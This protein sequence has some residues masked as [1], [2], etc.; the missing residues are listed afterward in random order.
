LYSPK[1]KGPK[2]GVPAPNVAPPIKRVS[3]AREAAFRVLDQIDN[4]PDAHSDDL[5]H[6]PMLSKLSQADKNL[7]TALVMGVLRWKIALEA[8]LIPLLARPDSRLPSQVATV[9]RLGAFQLLHMDRIPAHAAISESVDLVRWAGEPHS[10]GMVNAVLRKLAGSS[11]S[12]VGTRPEPTTDPGAPGLVSETWEVTT[13]VSASKKPIFET[14]TALA[15]RLA[16]P[17]WM[18]DRW[19]RTYGR[20]AAEAICNHDQAEPAAPSLFT[21]T[22]DLSDFDEG[23]A[24]LDDG[25]R[26]VA[27]LAA[28]ASPLARRVWDACAAPGGKTTVLASRLA[29][30]DV[31]ATDISP[32]RLRRMGYRLERELGKGRVRTL[33]TDAMKLPATE[34]PFDLIL[35]DA[36]CSGTGTLARNPEIK[37]RLGEYAEASADLARQAT[38]QRAILTAA[39]QRLAPGGRLVYS[40][41]SLEPEENERVVAAVLA[42][43]TGFRLASLTP[44]VAELGERLTVPPET[45]LAWLRDDHLRTLPGANFSGDGFFLAV[46]ERT[47]A[48]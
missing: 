7:T 24:R 15:T 46:F 47:P 26:L 43:T 33:E 22:L 4:N 31:L 5:L 44:L 13:P 20:A 48:S 17:G 39:L 30:A 18:V 23:T 35:C 34:G 6:G 37:E 29:T 12:A 28:L 45:S 21:D 2:K 8:R 32:K 40:T 3:P 27:E 16:H 1:P 25:S 38:R 9:L 10:S 11:T 36:P 19:A 14:I 41:C 42:E